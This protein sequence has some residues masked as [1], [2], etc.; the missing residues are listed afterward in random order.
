VTNIASPWR[1]RR[2]CAYSKQRPLAHKSR[3]FAV[4]LRDTK[5][6]STY[7][8]RC[9]SNAR[10]QISVENRRRGKLPRFSFPLAFESKACDP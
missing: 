8:S 7:E 2:Y 1:R 10:S 9:A 4:S 5:Q 6:H 3:M